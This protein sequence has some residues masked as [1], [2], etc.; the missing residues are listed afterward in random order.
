MKLR[1]PINSRALKEK[2]PQVY[3]DFFSKCQVVASAPHFFTWAGEYIGY[4]GGV[5]TMQKLPFRIYVGIE[6]LPSI[7]KRELLFAPE[8]RS[9]SQKEMIFKKDYFDQVSISRVINFLNGYLK[10]KTG[11][12]VHVLSEMPLGGSGSAGAFC[13]ALALALALK[14]GRVSYGDIK[15]WQGVSAAELKKDKSFAFILYL[16]WKIMA[17]YRGKETSGATIFACLLSSRFPV[18]FNLK[19]NQR[20]SFPLDIDSN[21]CLI[22]EVEY[23]G[24][25]I[26]EL[27][28]IRK[29]SSWPV[30]FGLIF[31]GEPKGG[32]PFPTCQLQD[33]I[34][35]V[36]KFSQ[37][38]L[39][40]LCFCKEE[41]TWHN[42]L[43]VMNFLSL[44]ILINLGKVLEKGAR[45]DVL[46]NLL[47]SIDKHQVLFLLLGFLSGNVEQVS[48]MLKYQSRM[49]DEFGCGVK[50]VSTTKKDIL[51]FVFPYGRAEGVLGR[52]LPKLKKEL[53]FDVSL[54]YASFLDGV[55]EEGAKIEQFLEKGI[56][57][58]F[59]SQKTVVIEEFSG[60]GDRVKLLLTM[61]EFGK[62]KEGVDLL[63][64]NNKVAIQGVPLNSR[65]LHSSKR[66][67]E[68]LTLLLLNQ[69]KEVSNSRLR[70]SSY[71]QDRYELQGKVVGPLTKIFKE[72]TGKKLPILVNGGVVEFNIR[73]DFGDYKIWVR[74][75]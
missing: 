10:N 72:R 28:S 42:A 70:R 22:D 30:D 43:E 55:E 2:F 60:R 51:L 66:A 9:Y 23:S 29:S 52:V 33:E 56:Y 58:H 74:Q 3:R 38:K 25:R 18:Y 21:Y 13:A 24:G 8:P 71:A 20:V 75:K 54:G 61:E 11:F 36:C 12:R 68:V 46:R 64:E 15:R 50:S 26:E 5:M 4:W 45:E 16:G 1:E 73:L 19:K 7:E 6:N 17:A 59:I 37:D 48:A 53:K 32:S 49:I 65:E 63:V 47:K 69:G 27:F 41:D 57:S 62:A 40:G 31:L 35:G 67:I 14:K 34:A 44:Q 39:D